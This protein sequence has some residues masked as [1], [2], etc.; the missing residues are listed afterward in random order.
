[1]LYDTKGSEQVALVSSFPRK[2]E[3]SADRL[4]PGSRPE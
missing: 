1:M 4:D 3:S 2:W